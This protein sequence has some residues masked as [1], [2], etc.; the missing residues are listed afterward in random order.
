MVLPYY[1]SRYFS[2]STYAQQ[3][4]ESNSTTQTCG[5]Y[6]NKELPIN[7]SRNVG[8][9]F[10]GGKNICTSNSSNLRLDTGLLNSH[11]HLGIN[12]PPSIRFAFRYVHECAPLLVDKYTRVNSSRP[13]NSANASLELLYG[14]QIDGETVIDPATYRIPQP[15]KTD[16]KLSPNGDF[17]L[18]S[19]DLPNIKHSY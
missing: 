10:P 2:A 12:T 15:G 4:Y 8:C 13:F 14:A 3:C 11:D 6:V 17:R 16:P 7:A 1:E 18:K 19:V 9:P 5:T